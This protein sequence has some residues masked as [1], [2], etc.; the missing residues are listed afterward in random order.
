M[1]VS[2]KTIM[3]IKLIIYCFSLLGN[4]SYIIIYFYILYQIKFGKNAFQDL[5]LGTNF[6]LMLNIS[7]F[8][9]SISEI[10]FCY[11]ILKNNITSKNGSF[12]RSP[13]CQT[14][15]FFRNYSE[16]TSICCITILTYLFYQSTNEMIFDS[17][18][19]TKQ[20]I[21]GIL[22]S[23]LFPLLFILPPLFTEK[24]SFIK[25][26]CSFESKISCLHIIFYIFIIINVIFQLVFLFI[27]FCYYNSKINYI[28]ESNKNRDKLLYISVW[29]FLLFPIY[30]IISFFLKLINRIEKDNMI[31]LMISE[32][33]L[34]FSG[35]VDS[36]ICLILIRS[37]FEC[38]KNKDNEK[39]DESEEFQVLSQE[40]YKL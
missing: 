27:S 37:V 36:I 30:L 22:Y 23:F 12:D 2:E 25:T 35:V 10:V 38:C 14:I 21:Y 11:Y 31:F 26:R 15:A 40:S 17:E 34:A 20:F 13:F 19:Q 1:S 8:F 29:I 33:M 39:S 4:S 28:K 5:G 6:M 32:I 18:R 16:L 9:S 7:R 24:F 3:I